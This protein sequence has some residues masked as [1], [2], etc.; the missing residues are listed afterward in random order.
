MPRKRDAAKGLAFLSI[1]AVFL[2]VAALVAYNG[3]TTEMPP[4]SAA[5][6]GS[7][8][9]QRCHESQYG[10]RRRTLHVQMT[11]PIE[12]ARVE[13]SFGDK[14]PVRLDAYGRSYA[15]EQRNGRYFV[16]VARGGRPAERF[17]V[18][19]TLGA[20]RFQGYLSKLPDGRIYV[21]PIFWHNK[22]TRWV[23]WKQITPA[24]DD[25]SHDL[26][27]IWNV[28]CVNCHATNLAKNFD[29]A[30]KTYATTWTEM[31]IAC[32]ACHGP[33]REHIALMD[34]WRANPA[35]KPAFDTSSNN[36]D[37]GRTLRIFSPRSAA[38]R[39]VFDACGYCHGNKNNAFFGFKPGEH[40]EDYALPFLFSQPIPPNDPQGEFW[41]DG[42][43]SRFNRPQAIMQ[44]GCFQRGQATCTSCHTMHGPRN[45]H[46]LKIEVENADGTHTK[47]SDGLCLQ[48]H[49]SAPASAAR[50]SAS[51]S[52][53]RTWT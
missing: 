26:R 39:Q 41:P 17:E 47:Q 6:V 23:D 10:T 38:P 52:A 42:R 9:C 22:S 24:P 5:Y 12:E 29:V 20:R 51:A 2:A 27:Q 36:R 32:E 4:A 45:S 30:T 40:L 15:M 37:L 13:G 3:Q 44:T 33:G 34:Q 18:N 11:K 19:Y 31:G 16:T 48:C 50:N 25:P 43:P 21:L 53:E 14:E 1:A 7:G 28:T 46:S 49:G 35:A 8:A